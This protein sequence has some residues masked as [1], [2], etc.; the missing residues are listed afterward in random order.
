MKN[1]ALFIKYESLTEHTRLQIEKIQDTLNTNF[2]PG[3]II[4][5]LP[6]L[7][8]SNAFSDGYDTQTLMHK[9]HGTEM[10]KFDWKNQL[11]NDLLRYIENNY[12]WW[13]KETGYMV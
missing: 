11:D 5:Q 1:K 3:E 10:K 12:H 7:I 8:K 2:E 13:F 4:R 9:I 6:E